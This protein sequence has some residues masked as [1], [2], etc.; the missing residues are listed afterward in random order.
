MPVGSVM[1][2]SLHV[3]VLHEKCMVEPGGNES[4]IRSRVCV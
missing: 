4:R 1:S 3:L 2:I